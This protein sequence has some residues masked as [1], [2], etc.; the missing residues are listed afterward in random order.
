MP[1]KDLVNF[2]LIKQCTLKAAKLV[3]C[4]IGS[5]VP[6]KPLLCLCKSALS[7]LASVPLVMVEWPRLEGTL[8]DHPVQHFVGEGA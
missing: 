2:I 7:F 5:F 1:V 6:L 4:G 8:K 3:H